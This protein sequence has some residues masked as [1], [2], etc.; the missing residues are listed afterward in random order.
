MW[1][2]CVNI[3]LVF[4]N[5]TS[6]KPT[7]TSLRS[8]RLL[9][10]DGGRANLGQFACPSQ[11]FSYYRGEKRPI[12]EFRLPLRCE[13][14]SLLAPVMDWGLVQSV[15]CLSCLDSLGQ[16]Q[17]AQKKMKQS[18]SQWVNKIKT[19]Q[20]RSMHLLWLCLFDCGTTL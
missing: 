11:A 20:L 19:S 16:P 13:C 12:G 2:P 7:L 4:F 1:F 17:Q 14:V 10:C 6:F 18:Y 5:R 8:C 3:F 15:L 9:S